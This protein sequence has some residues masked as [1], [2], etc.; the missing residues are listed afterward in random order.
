MIRRFRRL[1][2]YGYTRH[3]QPHYDRLTA[4]LDGRET[5]LVPGHRVSVR[6]A[7]FDVSDHRLFA[8]PNEA[9]PVALLDVA[10]EGVSA[11]P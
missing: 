3:A 5:T 8:D 10:V 2:R 11:R 4:A 7:P 1:R 6:Y 9:D